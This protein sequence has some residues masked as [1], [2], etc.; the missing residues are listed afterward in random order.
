[1]NSAGYEAFG[2]PCGE[3]FLLCGAFEPHLEWNGLRMNYR[4][5]KRL[6]MTGKPSPTR[7]SLRGNMFHEAH[8]KKRNS[9]D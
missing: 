8:G 9:A 7:E 1:M 4:I 2:R 5:F 3:T 6:L